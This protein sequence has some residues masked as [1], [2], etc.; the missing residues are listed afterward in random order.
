[1]EKEKNLK[2]VDHKNVEKICGLGLKRT[3]KTKSKNGKSFSRG[4]SFI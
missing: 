3:L 1:M 4:K 2:V